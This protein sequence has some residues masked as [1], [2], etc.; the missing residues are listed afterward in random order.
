NSDR[1]ATAAFVQGAVRDRTPRWRVTYDVTPT[2]STPAS[3]V[4]AHPGYHGEILSRG[5]I[6]GSGFRVVEG[7][8]G[9][10][11]LF[12]MRLNAQ[13][14]VTLKQYLAFIDDWLYAYLNGALVFSTTTGTTEV[15]EISWPLVPGDNLLQIVIND[16]AGS[17]NTLS[18]VGDLLS[19]SPG[20][21]FAPL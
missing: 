18:L 16:A 21:S 12:E 13:A 20:V 17:F 19:Q 1:L 6:I 3:I 15:G 4:S 11:Y 7:G 8:S 5:S 2:R 14:A 10:S 9:G